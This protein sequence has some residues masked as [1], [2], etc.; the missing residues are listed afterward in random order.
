MPCS[1]PRDV[2]NVL[3]GSLRSSSPVD[4][5][6]RRGRSKFGTPPVQIDGGG[7]GAKAQ[8]DDTE[9]RLTPVG[10]AKSRNVIAEINRRRG[11]PAVCCESLDVAFDSGHSFFLSRALRDNGSGADVNADR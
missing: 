2:Y 8:T 6:R 9:I 3:T 5:T 11:Y 4:R 10:S 7:D 1:T